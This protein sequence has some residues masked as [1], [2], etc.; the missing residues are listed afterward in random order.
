MNLPFFKIEFRH[1]PEE[2]QSGLQKLTLLNLF[3]ANPSNQINTRL[4]WKL[5]TGFEATNEN[6]CR[7][8]QRFYLNI[9]AGLSSELFQGILYQLAELEISD[10][11]T[12]YQD[13]YM[14][15]KL[16]IGYLGGI[17]DLI[18][19]RLSS[20]YSSDNY[21]QINASL[22]VN[23]FI[24]SQIRYLNQ[25]IDSDLE[26]ETIHSLAFIWYF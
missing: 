3:A 9:G 18:K 20:I 16:H 17:G 22:A 13:K 25:Q 2:H 10:K 12:I 5:D 19:Y 15:P 4:S 8:C 21:R 7:F 14:M 26:K 1:Y 6:E 23:L 24:N 11:K